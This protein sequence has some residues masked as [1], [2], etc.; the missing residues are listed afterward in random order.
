MKPFVDTNVLLY[1]LSNDADKS[2]AAETL[3]KDRVIVSVQVLNEFANVAHRKF[4]FSWAE[5]RAALVDI[6][7][8]S[9]VH[10]L[11]TRTHEL[12]LDI[13][14]RYGFA[15]Y[16][17]LIVA[18]ALEAGCKRLLSEDFQ[19]AQRIDGLRIENPFKAA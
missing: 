4:R 13:A 17:S 1:L 12:G 11:T 15:F 6:V 5:V 16:D 10:V 19:H 7:R 2:A 18:A 3:L 8:F 9:E 14:E